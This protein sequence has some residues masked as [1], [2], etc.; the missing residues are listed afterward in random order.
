MIVA[1]TIM[2]AH[3]ISKNS[4]SWDSFPIPDRIFVGMEQEHSTSSQSSDCFK[5]TFG[6]NIPSARD[7]PTP[8]LLYS[9]CIYT[10]SS[11]FI[12]LLWVAFCG[13]HILTACYLGQYVSMFSHMPDVPTRTLW[14]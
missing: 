14:R 1:G 3:R 5:E 9:V 13:R 10:H 8:D 2:A 7:I 11:I 4:T 12:I 6:V